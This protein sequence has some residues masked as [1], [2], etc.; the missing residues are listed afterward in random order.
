M[1]SY[2]NTRFIFKFSTLF[3]LLHTSCF[4]R[5]DHPESLSEVLVLEEYIGFNKYVLKPELIN[6]PSA[7]SAQ[8]LKKIPGANVN[9]NGT[10]TGIA[11]YRGMYGDRVNIL[12]D[13]IK[14]SSGGPNA[15]DTP[16]SYIPRSQLESLEIIRGIAP[17]SSGNET[18]GG[19]MRATSTQSTFT[20]NEQL[21][22]HGEASA[23]G[24]SVDSGYDVSTLMSLANKNHRMHIS[25]SRQDSDDYA[26]ANGDV[27]PS[28]Y[29][30]NSY[31]TGYGYQNENHEFGLEYVLNDTNE[32]G[33][34]ALPMD[35][36][37]IDA[38]IVRG[39]YKG[40]WN[41]VEVESKL[42]WSQIDHRM[43]NYE[44]RLPP[45]T[46]GGAGPGTMQRFSLADSED[47]G[48]GITANMA[49]AGGKLKFGTD[50]HL[51]DHNSDV[52]N[53]MS[54]AFLIEN[55]ND[56]NRDVFGF[57]GEWQRS[58]ASKWDMELGLRYTHI[59]MDAG[60]VSA[61]GFPMAGLATR[62]NALAAAFNASDRSKDD[63]NIDAVVKFTHSLLQDTNIEIGF[64]R[65]MRSPSYQE[66]YLWLPLQSTGGLADGNNYI[67]DINLDPEVSYQF[68][69]GLDWR[70]EKVYF[71]PRAYY[72]HVDDYIQGIDATNAN[73][74]A[75][76]TMANAM[77]G[78]SSKILQFANVDARLYGV[79]A[80]FGYHFND[81]WH[82][83]GTFSY[84]KGERRDNGDNL[85]RI[86]PT[87][88]RLG[89]TRDKNNWS[90]T[91]EVA[92]YLEKN[93]VS[94]VTNELE[95]SGYTLL[96]IYGHYKPAASG[97]ILTA[98]VDNLLDKNYAPH[99]GGVNRVR[100]V[101][102]ARGARIPG[103][104]INGFINVSYEW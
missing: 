12:I 55:Y 61:T 56:I 58:L 40:N 13:G 1:F 2:R 92:S 41:Q 24:H 44:L 85:Y 99:L 38:D 35:I 31:E 50:G 37:Y 89:L 16:I 86:S 6:A 21:E 34:P 95:T 77:T 3:L 101:D 64:A 63:D 11:Q 39:N 87:N 71:A 90:S 18:I 88:V 93:D 103:P 27:T 19:T 69:L 9:S 76:N 46:G 74:I 84:V 67:G 57:F 23:G 33:T 53:P 20:E 54:T 102:V 97:L 22:F 48:Y 72:H 4:V 60:T 80:D 104:G 73:A 59:S 66:R 96:N 81:D 45:L 10:V 75:F 7:D 47:V 17:V 70:N 5:A 62:A 14:I 52:F 8:L 43:S 30:R 100:N 94:G 25:A 29:D 28:E 78:S 32:S 42:Y 83:D 65:K 26:F 36:I 98:G 49:F 91:L 68:E 15:M 51:A 79:D 82:I